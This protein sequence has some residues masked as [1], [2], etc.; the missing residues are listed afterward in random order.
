MK[1]I[2]Q[3]VPALMACVSL[4][5]CA[6]FFVKEKTY[7]GGGGGEL[8]GAQVTSAVQ[9]AGGKA[10]I[11]LSAM[12]YNAGFGET[13]GP[14]LWR[15]EATGTEGIHESLIVHDLRV[16]TSATNRT[17]PYPKK[18]LNVKSPFEPMRGRKNAGKVF[19]KYQLPGKLEVFPEKDGDITLV[20]DIS[21]QTSSAT[22]RER[23]SFK[24]TPSIAR[25][26]QSVFVPT[27]IVK[28][29]GKD[30]PTE[31]D[32]SPDPNSRFSDDF[33]GPNSGF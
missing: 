32:L 22:Q 3:S 17:E 31:W 30:D 12:V 18:W 11:S 1:G 20:A 10:G 25:D 23:L 9:P 14:F 19:A 13:D 29:F 21:I 24:M 5:S 26:T 6:Q 4:S 7:V 33:W 8:N 15:I 28:S 2:L 27:E 16:T